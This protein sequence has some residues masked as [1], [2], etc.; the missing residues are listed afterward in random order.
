MRSNNG[1]QPTRKKLRAADAERVCRAWPVTCRVRVPVP[2]NRRAE[3]E[4]NGKGV[5]ARRGLKE[6]VAEA[7]WRWTRT[8]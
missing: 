8:R 3:G 2:G 4:A 7:V 6:A 5:A 1:M